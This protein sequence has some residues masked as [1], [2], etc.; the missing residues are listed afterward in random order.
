MYNKISGFS[1]E[2]ASDINVQFE[3][4]GKLNMKYF[5][6]RF[7]NGK[8]ISVLND[9]EVIAL[10]A[11]MDECG[12][13]ASSIGSPVGKIKL[14]DDFDAHF[15]MFKRVVKTAKM[16]DCNYIRIFSFY[17]E[18]GE[19]TADERALVLERLKMFIAYAK[20]E[21][22]VLLHENEKDIYGDIAPRCLDIM[23]ELVC[24]NFK[25]VF[26]PANFIQSGQDT[27]EAYEMLKDYVAYM[28]IKD[29]M[30][31]DGKVV[32]AGYGDGS[33]KY[34]LDSLFADGFD[35]F[36]SLEPHLGSFEGLADLELDDK[37]M[38]LEESGEGK[39]ILAYDSLVALL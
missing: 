19:W 7:V 31:E 25:A 35:G 27:K 26:D 14:T 11:K 4:L 38:S 34:I 17:H 23:K 8:S 2:I 5:E 24:D 22:V 12:I 28:H 21:K 37:M 32:P 10:K 29:A 1:D 6:P 30:K 18:G 9:E 16:L 33:L 13:K 36:L 39:F 20:E 15:E 3:A